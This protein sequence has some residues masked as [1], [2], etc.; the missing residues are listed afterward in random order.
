MPVDFMATSIGPSAMIHCEFR[1]TRKGATVTV[2]SCAGVWLVGVATL[3]FSAI[4][5]RYT[6]K[7]DSLLVYFTGEASAESLA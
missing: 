1:Q 2:N 6:F 3:I 5:P 7:R 4:C